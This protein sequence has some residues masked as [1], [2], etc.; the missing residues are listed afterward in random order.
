MN[1]VDSD[2]GNHVT[3][4]TPSLNVN[5]ASSGL[6]SLFVKQC[7]ELMFNYLNPIFHM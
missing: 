5:S 4:R 7:N 1:T 2:N 3:Q 6:N